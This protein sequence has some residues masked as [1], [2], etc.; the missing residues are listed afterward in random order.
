[1]LKRQRGREGRIY[2]KNLFIDMIEKITKE[3][4]LTDCWVCEGGTH[5]SE[6]W[7]WDS[8]S[9]GPLDILQWITSRKSMVV[10]KRREGE[11]KLKSTIIG[12]K[13]LSR[14]G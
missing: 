12:E 4:N 3:F 8:I 7:P 13:C 5:L 6:I 10:P 9:L 14:K 11:W 1:H 2:G